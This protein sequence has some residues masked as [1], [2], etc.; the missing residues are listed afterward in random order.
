M[1]ESPSRESA[2]ELLRRMGLIEQILPEVSAATNE[3]EQWQQ[4]L[5]LL[6]ALERPTLPKALAV[7]IGWPNGQEHAATVSKRWRLSNAE[8][9]RTSWLIKH[10]TALDNSPTKPW[11]KLQPVL[12]HA[13]A[14]E[15]LALY[16]A[17]ARLGRA[18]PAGVEFA[19][20]KL[21]LP[22][23]QLDPEPLISGD[24]LI[25]L[26]VPKGKLYS[27]LLQEARNAQLDGLLHSRE[28]AQRFVLRRWAEL[29][30]AGRR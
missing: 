28:D 21:A 11:S 16:R 7:L 5:A 25:Q 17:A 23:G 15:L 14:D 24:D 9:A 3:P 1:L 26:Q 30:D 8:A 27:V 29:R 12:A 13:G 10:G 18:D 20:Q 22:A 4:R 2:V 6:S 19:R